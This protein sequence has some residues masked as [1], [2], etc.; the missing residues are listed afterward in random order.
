[1]VGKIIQGL[2][3]QKKKM[4]IWIFGKWFN[5]FCGKYGNMRK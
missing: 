3:R 1:M 4:R 5:I 2:R